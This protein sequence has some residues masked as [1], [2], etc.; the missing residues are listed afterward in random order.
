M[1]VIHS[2]VD[3]SKTY[4]ELQKTIGELHGGYIKSGF[5]EG[6]KVGYPSKHKI[7]PVESMDMSEIAKIAAWNEFGVPKK[8]SESMRG[9]M[10]GR[11]TSAWKLVPRA[12]FRTAIDGGREKIFEMSNKFANLAMIGKLTVDQAFE[13]L[14][15]YMQSIIRESIRHGQWAPNAPSTI[16]AKGPSKPL[17]DTGQMINSVTHVKVTGKHAGIGGPEVVKA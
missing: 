16:K 7:G 12:F 17:I 15:L 4:Q 3:K 9:I 13:N 5:P 6:G 2:C 8:L 10:T 14:G 1:G 11:S